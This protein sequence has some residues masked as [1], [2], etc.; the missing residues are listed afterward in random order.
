MT[1]ARCAR[2][3]RLM[4]TAPYR[5]CPSCL[6]GQGQEPARVTVN[7]KSRSMPASR[8]TRTHS[9]EVPRRWSA[10]CAETATVDGGEV[11]T[12]DADVHRR[13][14]SPAIRCRRR[15]RL[16]LAE[17]ATGRS[18]LDD[19][20]SARRRRPRLAAVVGAGVVGERSP[21]LVQLGSASLKTAGRL[22]GGVAQQQRDASG[23]HSRAQ[24]Q[25][26]RTRCGGQSGLTERE[27]VPD[28]PRAARLTGPQR[29]P[30]TPRSRACRAPDRG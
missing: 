4:L 21:N 16:A 22:R 17:T 26:S 9:S 7:S 1:R 29:S 3:T 6:H 24:G 10:C 5:R 2:L 30:G 8:W 27:V 18:V 23:R 12:A 25:G 28:Y 11:A 14:A 13:A 19:R 15:V 20:T